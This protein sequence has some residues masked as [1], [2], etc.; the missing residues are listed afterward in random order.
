[1]INSLRQNREMERKMNVLERK[2]KEGERLLNEI[3]REKER[4]R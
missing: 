2:E 1:M 4:K 3:K